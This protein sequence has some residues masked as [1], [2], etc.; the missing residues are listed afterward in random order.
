MKKAQNHKP[1]YSLTKQEDKKI[2]MNDRE[3]E[4]LTEEKKTAKST[5]Q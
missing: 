4:R 3:R 2:Q 1:L 5:G